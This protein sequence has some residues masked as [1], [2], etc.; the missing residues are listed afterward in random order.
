MVNVDRLCL[1]RYPQDTQ[2]Q[3]KKAK[4]KS[5]TNVGGGDGEGRKKI[6]SVFSHQAAAVTARRSVTGWRA[7]TGRL[8]SRPS[9]ARTTKHTL[10][11]A[12]TVGRDVLKWASKWTAG[13]SKGDNSV[14]RAAY[15]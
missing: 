11:A 9:L 8:L 15:S 1:V 5:D 10:P 3:H 4:T 13:E 6:S 7:S 2:I 14:I 12:A